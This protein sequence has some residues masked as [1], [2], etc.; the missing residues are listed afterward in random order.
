M[1]SA[2]EVRT[3]DAKA[4]V[5][6]PKSFANATVIVEEISDTEIRI[7]K[8]RVIPEDEVRFAEENRTP[9]SDRD[10]DFFLKMLENPPE[11]NEALKK[12]IAKHRARHRGRVSD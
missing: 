12:A 8:A 10:R 3:T 2:K 5:S 4:R 11:A 7:R 9:L 6:L 1:A